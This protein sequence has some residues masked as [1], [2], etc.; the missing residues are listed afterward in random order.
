MFH[1]TDDLFGSE[2]I[3]MEPMPLNNI[4]DDDDENTMDD[5]RS[6]SLLEFCQRAKELLSINQPDFV[7]FVLTGRDTDGTQACI[8]PI[9]NRVPQDH[10]LEIIR[11]YDS[12]LGISKTIRVQASIT[13]YPV[14]KR[15]DTLSKNIH[16]RYQFSKS[17]V[18]LHLCLVLSY[19]LIH[20]IRLTSQRIYIESPTF[21]LASGA[22]TT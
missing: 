14:A 15:E 10:P 4:Y 7:R 16:I 22:S 12:L 11:D 21:V 5:R 3:P 20:D 9:L 6:L 17:S 1:Y 2:D 13:V 18:S 8:D 19:A